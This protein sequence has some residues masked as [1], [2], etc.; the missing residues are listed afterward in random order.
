MIL[1]DFYPP[2]KK[3]QG[4]YGN[5]L[6]PSFRPTILSW[7]YLQNYLGYQL[8]TSQVDRSH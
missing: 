8:Q 3:R 2:P 4:G 1:L 6:H 5:S 7:A